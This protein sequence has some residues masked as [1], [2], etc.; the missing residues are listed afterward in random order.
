M[1]VGQLVHP[2]QESLA[3]RDV[4]GDH[5]VLREGRGVPL[6][7]LGDVFQLVREQAAGGGA[8]APLGILGK[9][10]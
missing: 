6:W 9:R 4:V 8:D 5:A 2:A 10:R 3:V 1:P 7:P